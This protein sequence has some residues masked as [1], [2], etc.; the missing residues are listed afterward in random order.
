MQETETGQSTHPMQIW[1]PRPTHRPLPPAARDI[2]PRHQ[3]RK[4]V[5]RRLHILIIPYA[6]YSLHLEAEFLRHIA[7]AR[8]IELG[9]KQDV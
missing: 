1:Q 4:R 3:A 5:V 7:L 6:Q 2:A 8:R 9:D